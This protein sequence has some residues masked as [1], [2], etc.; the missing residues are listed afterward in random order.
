MNDNYLVFKKH[1]DNLFSGGFPDGLNDIA[2]IKRRGFDIIFTLVPYDDISALEAKKHGIVIKVI[3]MT[4]NS[5][6]NTLHSA[7]VSGKK[8]VVCCIYGN[9][10]D[11]ICQKYL[12]TLREHLRKMPRNGVKKTSVPRRR[13]PR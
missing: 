9:S 3:D 12:R 8:V 11:I 5:Y 4:S 10:G 13:I 7:L 2:E 6:F 1:T